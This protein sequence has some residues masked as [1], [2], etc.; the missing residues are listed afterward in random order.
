MEYLLDKGAKL[1]IT[2]LQGQNVLHAAVVGESKE[3]VD[4]LL[5]RCQNSVWD[6][7]VCQL[8]SISLFYLNVCR[9]MKLYHDEEST[10]LII[11]K[12]SHFAP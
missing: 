7:Q 2:N 9:L 5:K 12:E 10:S 6:K 3:C 4:L 1:D 8:L 11:P